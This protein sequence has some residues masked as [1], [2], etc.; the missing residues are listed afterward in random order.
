VTVKN[1]YTYD[2]TNAPVA[3]EVDLA[4]KLVEAGWVSTPAGDRNL[5]KSFALDE[6]SVRVVAVTNA[7]QPQP[8]DFTQ[9]GD[10][11]SEVPST[12]FVGPL[13]R[14]ATQPYDTV[15]NPFITVLWR[16]P[17]TMLA[18][19]SRLFVVYLDTL[20]N[21]H[22][23]LPPAPPQTLCGHS[24]SLGNGT[25]LSSALN[26]LFWS[27]SGLTLYGQLAPHPSEVQT[28]SVTPLYPGT[29]VLVS[30]LVGGVYQPVNSDPAKFPPNPVRFDQAFERKDPLFVR[31]GTKDP[32][33]FRVDADKPVIATVVSSGFVPSTDG[34]P[35]GTDF[36]FAL[37]HP[38][39]FEQDT[40]YFMAPSGKQTTVVVEPVPAL[41]ASYT[42]NLNDDNNIW[43]YTI[44]NREVQSY[45]PNNGC[46]PSSDPPP[47]NA[48]LLPAGP[49]LYHA[50]VKPGG[51]PVLLQ[52]QPSDGLSPVPASNGSP[53]GSFFQAAASWTDKTLQSGPGVLPNCSSNNRPGTWLGAGADG[54]SAAAASSP[55]HSPA[56]IDPP[57][58]VGSRN[59]PPPWP[60]AR[61]P[62]DYTTQGRHNLEATLDR[63]VSF[64]ATQPMWLFAGLY[65]AELAG[66]DPKPPNGAVYDNSGIPIINGPLLGDGVA[67]RFAGFGPA[68]VVAPFDDTVVTAKLKYASSGNAFQQN[69][70]GAGGTVTYN[71][72]STSD[73]LLGYRIDANKPV[74]VY[75]TLG[76]SAMLAGVPAFLTATVGAAEFWGYLLKVSSPTGLDPLSGAVQ[77]GSSITYSI[78]VTNL[79]HGVGGTNLQDTVVLTN[80]TP[81][82]GWTV[83][84][85]TASVTL[86]TG[87]TRTVQLT[88]TP[89]SGVK[90]DTF[91]I[92]GLRATSQG[93]PLVQDTL[94]TVTL[95]KNTSGVGL[96]FDF[97]GGLQEKTNVTDEGKPATF[98][99]VVKNTGSVEDDIKLSLLPGPEEVLLDDKGHEVESVTLGSNKSATLTLKVTLSAADKEEQRDTTVTAA[100]SNS[101]SAF[102]RIS[103]T[104]KVDRPSDLSLKAGQTVVRVDPGQGAVF[105]LVVGNLGTDPTKDVGSAKDVRFLVQSDPSPFW[106]NVTLCFPDPVTQRC[107]EPIPSTLT[108]GQSIAF[109]AT[110][111]PRTDAPAGEV[112]GLRISVT[113]QDT[114]GS[115][116]VFLYAVVRPLHKLNVTL[117]GIPLQASSLGLPQ[118]VPLR[119]QNGG[120]LDEFLQPQVS[121]LPAGWSLELPSLVAVLRGATQAFTANLTVAA[122]TAPGLYKVAIDMVSVDGNRTTLLL[123]TQVGAFGQGNLT[124]SAGLKAQPGMD[125]HAFFPL[126]NEGNTPLK[127]TVLAASGEPWTLRPPPTPLVIEPGAKTV[128][129][130]AWQVPATASDGNTTHTAQ[131]VLAPQDSGAT[132]EQR[133]LSVQVSVGRADLAVAVAQAYPGAAGTLVQAQIRNL[134]N[135]DA[136]QVQVTLR[137]G[138]RDVGNVTVDTIPALGSSNVTLLAP[139]P[140]SGAL[141]VLVDPGNRIVE[142]DESNN[143]AAVT[144]PEAQA[145]PFPQ[146][147]LLAVLL[148]GLAAARQSRAGRRT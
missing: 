36:Y 111:T 53:T 140:Q 65:P 56:Q 47:T 139:N 113:A 124:G 70:V 2:L 82:P 15:S 129:D 73:G 80:T 34:G 119:L 9:A 7:G 144:A 11:R 33:L 115:P 123:P 78:Q 122:S 81:T 74:L 136:H 63:P 79:G 95:L 67:R 128:L 75:P 51:A 92:V 27:G 101:L 142:R 106:G 21:G 104:T 134:G 62:T 29:T 145:S 13:R 102:A 114:P 57:D 5:T 35:L 17:G 121:D 93:N 23:C 107:Q 116:E 88:V 3:A 31:I 16:V 103:A 4:K 100:S 61:A 32:M 49:G 8:V 132:P 126:A 147:A 55:E 99:V 98:K 110:I 52:L 109:T 137:S 138:D 69:R 12:F 83:H 91:G 89:G 97:V 143:Q 127:V 148:A 28:V 118:S 41:G 54:D 133:V 43:N 85:D 37:T 40:V 86:Q 68:N 18:G 50:H 26:D 1:P 6:A 45:S 20:T 30:T 14:H 76:S 146:A 77:S 120:N 22:P 38:A 25:V 90:A 94:Q 39:D 112:N 42:F 46:T 105:P 58:S 141:A 125:V 72:R 117:P 66:R 87:Q 96:W 135:R 19:E 60:V 44:G 71:P 131:V 24:P 84:L 10:K 48:P 59:P 108:P 64:Q 130:L